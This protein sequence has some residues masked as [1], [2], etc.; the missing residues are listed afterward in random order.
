M[1]ATGSRR[2]SRSA[3]FLRHA[4]EHRRHGARPDIVALVFVFGLCFSLLGLGEK[5][6]AAPIGGSAPAAEWSW[7]SNSATNVSPA[8][9]DGASKGQETREQTKSQ[10]VRR[11]R[12]MM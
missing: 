2:K 4:R 11:R 8:R 9:E 10:L 1:F 12:A 5:G 6:L 7:L 3:T